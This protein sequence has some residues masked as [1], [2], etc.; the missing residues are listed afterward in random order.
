MSFKTKTNPQMLGNTKDSD[1][2]I[3]Y[4]KQTN[5]KNDFS[6]A[7]RHNYSLVAQHISWPAG[8]SLLISLAFIL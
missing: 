4:K 3:T 8:A 6:A 5:K 1:L 2:R 7:W